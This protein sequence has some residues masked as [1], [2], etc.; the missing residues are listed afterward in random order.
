M[1]F[2]IPEIEIWAE[3]HLRP[4][5]FNLAGQ[6]CRFAHFEVA[7][8]RLKLKLSPKPPES[9]RRMQLVPVNR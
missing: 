4:T 3:E 8:E 1:R 5:I 7:A 2:V 6:S 9:F